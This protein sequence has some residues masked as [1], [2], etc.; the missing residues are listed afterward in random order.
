MDLPR[1]PFKAQFVCSGSELL[2]LS[3][4]SWKEDEDEEEVE[5]EDDREEVVR[6][7]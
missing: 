7:V 4:S 2:A 3:P 5:E 6:I 1:A